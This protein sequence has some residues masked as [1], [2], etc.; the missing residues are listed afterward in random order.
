MGYISQLFSIFKDNNYYCIKPKKRIYCY[1]CKNDFNI[2]ECNI[3]PL[4]DI[5]TEYLDYKDINSIFIDKNFSD[6][7][8][9]CPECLEK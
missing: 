3:N 4:I 9:L 5:Q 8:E 1:K 2:K 7:N 6:H